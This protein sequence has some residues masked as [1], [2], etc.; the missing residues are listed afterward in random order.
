MNKNEVMREVYYLVKNVSEEIDVKKIMSLS[1]VFILIL[2]VIFP[3]SLHAQ[4]NVLVAENTDKTVETL[5]VF[6]SDELKKAFSNGE[7]IYTI[8]LQNDIT[9]EENTYDLKVQ[10]NHEITLLG[11]GHTIYFQNEYGSITTTGGTLNRYK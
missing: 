9:V 2:S 5:E 8:S 10:K 4:E 1:M 7:G 3:I 11:N 6:N